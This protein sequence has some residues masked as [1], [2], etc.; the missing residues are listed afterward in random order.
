M[1]YRTG[2][3]KLPLESTTTV[4]TRPTK[5]GYREIYRGT[6]LAQR[7]WVWVVKSHEGTRVAVD[8]HEVP[9]TFNPGRIMSLEDAR[10]LHAA[11]TLALEQA[12]MI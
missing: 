4:S 2:D 8:H 5:F 12:K 1:T 6:E 10:S 3:E 11:L 7:Y 9:D